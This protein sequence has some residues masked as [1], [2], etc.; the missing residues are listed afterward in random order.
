MPSMTKWTKF[1]QQSN[2]TSLLLALWTGLLEPT[3]DDELSVSGGWI[4]FS[5]K[6]DIRHFGQYEL[7]GR[8]DCRRTLDVPAHHGAICAR[9]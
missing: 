7:G 4:W 1:C 6:G 8:G 2:T 3:S 5:R 9:D